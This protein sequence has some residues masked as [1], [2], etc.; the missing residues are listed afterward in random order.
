LLA[1]LA[2]PLLVP[3]ARSPVQVFATED[4]NAFTTFDYKVS[5]RW[6]ALQ[7]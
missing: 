2:Q 6:L 4:A 5:R 1:L 3:A 7:L